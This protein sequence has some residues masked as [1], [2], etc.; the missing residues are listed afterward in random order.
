[1][2]KLQTS[3][4]GKRARYGDIQEL[5]SKDGYELGGN[6]DFEKGSFDS[7]LNREEGETIYLRIPFA[8][9]EGRLDDHAATIA[10]QTPYLIKHVVNVGL[11][12]DE[13]SLLTATFNQFQEPVD[14]DGQIHDKTKWAEI[15]EQAVEQ[16]SNYL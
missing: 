5:F 2:L 12:H 6:W 3:L 16:L 10:F 13:S 11:D 7:V 14:P 15:G 4:E 9:E 8:V 1:M